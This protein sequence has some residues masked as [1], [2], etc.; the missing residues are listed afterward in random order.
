MQ[1]L[2]ENYRINQ[3]IELTLHFWNIGDVIIIL[4]LN[5]QYK[6][7]QSTTIKALLLKKKPE[8]QQNF[9]LWW[10]LQKSAPFP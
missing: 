9:W 10:S 2:G 1:Y 5:V 7:Y 4:E 3:N 8:Q 6:I